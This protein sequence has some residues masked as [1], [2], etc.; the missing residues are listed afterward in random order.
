MSSGIFRRKLN[1]VHYRR[2]H[3]VPLGVSGA[4][5]VINATLATKTLTTF[6]ATVQADID[7][8][9]TATLATKSLSTFSATVALGTN[10]SATLATK[11][12]T[13]FP[14]VVKLSTNISATLATK[15]IASFTATVNAKTTITATLATKTLTTF[16]ASIGLTTD[17]T[18]TLATKTLTTFPAVVD[19]SGATSISATLATK[20]ITTFPATISLGQTAI[21]AT[22]ASKFYKTYKAVVT[23]TFVPIYGLPQVNKTIPHAI[24]DPDE[25]QRVLIENFSLL[26]DLV[27]VPG[28]LHTHRHDDSAIALTQDVY[29]QIDGYTHKS[30]KRKHCDIDLTT[31]YMEIDIDGVYAFEYFLEIASGGANDY[32]VALRNGED[33]LDSHDFDIHG[34]GGTTF[35]YHNL[36]GELASPK[37]KLNMAIKCTSASPSPVLV[38]FN[39]FII[40][41]DNYNIPP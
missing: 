23:S 4:A 38:Q 6:P 34:A 22:R 35:Q 10:I 40:R 15:T 33:V 2:K 16:P 25:Q 37:T 39:I 17:I 9:I 26:T 27:V 8:S 24:E 13:T 7:T 21:L 14:A 41:V 30:A 32:E 19:L 11:S 1:F 20:T 12:L 31:G 36:I 5:T 18:A 29:H 3:F 28:Y